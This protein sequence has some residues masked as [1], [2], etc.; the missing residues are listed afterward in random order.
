[1]SLHK[2]PLFQQPRGHVQVEQGATEGATVGVNVWNADGTLFVP[3]VASTSSNP[4]VSKTLWELVLKIPPNVTALQNAT[5]TGLFVVTASGT[6]ALRTIADSATV[7]WTNAGGIAGNPSASVNDDSITYAKMQD[8]SAA[9]KLL[10]R[11][12][13]GSGDPQEITLGSGL[14][15]SGTTL[16][17]TGGGTS[18][19]TTVKKTAD[20][21]R[22]S[23]TTLT[24]DSQLTTVLA[25]GTKYAFRAHMRHETASATMDLKSMFAYSGTLTSVTRRGVIVQASS[26]S[27]FYFMA[28]SLNQVAPNVGLGLVDID[29]EIELET[30]TAG[31]L[32][33]QW[34][35]NTS[36][37]SN[38]TLHAGSYLEYMTV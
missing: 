24:D 4:V 8:V 16:S 32:V 38:L 27:P 3:A 10:G 36:E 11:G 13:S 15:M 30:N 17:A 29:Y 1:M 14:S 31:T 18:A 12:D 6:G 7:G 34:S 28:A 9:S 26:S 21:N 5:G 23:T 20:E 22:A 2:V 25:A 19:W 33:Y 35:Q 37:A